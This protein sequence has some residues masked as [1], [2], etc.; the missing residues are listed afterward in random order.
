M[1]ASAVAGGEDQ[2]AKWDAT[3]HNGTTKGNEGFTH[4]NIALA[5]LS[6]KEKRAPSA[7]QQYAGTVC[8]RHGR[9]VTPLLSR[10]NEAVPLSR[11]LMENPSL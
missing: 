3:L 7:R 11:I 8:S 4:V 9:I 6:N 2:R 5:R 1:I 10:I